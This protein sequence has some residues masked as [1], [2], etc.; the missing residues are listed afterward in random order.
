MPGQA[1]W[2]KYHEIL[3]ERWSRYAK[4]Y[5]LM[6]NL[7]T[8]HL[9]KVSNWLGIP[10][11]I[12]NVLT[13]GT[14]FTNAMDGGKTSLF[15][16][17]IA[18]SMV[19]ISGCLYA[20]HRSMGIESLISRHKITAKKYTRIQMEVDSTL[21]YER[22]DREANAS[23][24]LEHI[25]QM[26]TEVQ[27]VSPEIPSIILSETIKQLDQNL[28]SISAGYE[29]SVQNSSKRAPPVPQRPLKPILVETTQEDKEPDQYLGLHNKKIDIAVNKLQLQ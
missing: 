5:S 13:A 17:Y 23:Q 22:K 27:D 3:L 28:V 20:A 11:H 29:P 1:G 6:H 25:K 2:T 10:L 24:F 19:V 15:Q 26:I 21:C 4:S 9:S 7:A 16:N 12:L 18:G 14:V 8:V